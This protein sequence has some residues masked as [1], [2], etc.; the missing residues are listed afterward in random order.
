MRSSKLLVTLFALLSGCAASDNPSDGGFFNGV[1]AISDGTYDARIAAQEQSVADAQARNAR[2][3][4]T[5]TSLAAQIGAA[6][7][8]LA[9][10]KF[11]LL[12]QKNSIGGLSVATTARID[13]IL[14]ANPTGNNPSAKLAALQNTIAQARALSGELASLSG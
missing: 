1:K 2:L 5:Q 7:N 13:S 4:A 6:E 3:A 14:N 8:E 9:K 10:L 11:T 12:Q